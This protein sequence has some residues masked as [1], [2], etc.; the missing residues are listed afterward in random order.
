M[1]L[2]STDVLSISHD[3]LSTPF[4]ASPETQREAIGLNLLL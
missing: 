2:F 1:C 4:Q 3:D